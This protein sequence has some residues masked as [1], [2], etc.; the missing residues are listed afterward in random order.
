MPKQAKIDAVSELKDRIAAAT[1]LYF[2]DFTKVPANDFNAL[3]RRLGEV[4][5]PVR[6][7]KNRLALRALTESGTPAEIEAILKGPTSMV[8]AGEDPVAPARIIREVMRKLAAL[9][10]KG[11]Y[12]DRNLY[13]AESFEFLAALPT[14][15]E[16]RGQVVGVLE[17]PI[18]ELVFG[19]EGLI[20]D[21]VYVLDQV[22]DRPVGVPA[23]AVA[24]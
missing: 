8:F 15:F 9:K 19:L 18:A 10:V 2:V 21:L 23:E 14:K 5:A 7:V 1:A 11:A 16:L 12:L 20:S 22:K 3:R 6:V 4:S 13:Q 24:S 17:A